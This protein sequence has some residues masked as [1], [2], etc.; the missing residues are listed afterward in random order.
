M[1][2]RD[3]INNDGYLVIPKVFT[4]NEIDEFKTE[5]TQYTRTKFKNMRL[6]V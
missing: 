2:V 4:K 6:C 1:N 3:K 5:I